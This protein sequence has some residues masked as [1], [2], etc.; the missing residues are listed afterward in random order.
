MTTIDTTQQT[1]N[2]VQDIRNRFVDVPRDVME[3]VDE[4]LKR[5]SIDH[6]ASLLWHAGHGFGSADLYE[7]RKTLFPPDS[8]VDPYTAGPP[9]P[10]STP[11]LRTSGL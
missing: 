6:V 10:R 7:Y 5:E 3:R 11:G 1:P 4:A 2:L 8:M 9:T